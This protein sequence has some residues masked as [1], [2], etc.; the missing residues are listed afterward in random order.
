MQSLTPQEEARVQPNGP[1]IY[2]MGGS[3][4]LAA[5]KTKATKTVRTIRDNVFFIF[6]S[7]LF[8]VPWLI[9]SLFGSFELPG[10]IVSNTLPSQRKITAKPAQN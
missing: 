2:W 7:S 6:V 1:R 9:L 5:I 10:L 3:V 8:C 4:G